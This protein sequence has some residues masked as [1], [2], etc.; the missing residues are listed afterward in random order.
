MTIIQKIFSSASEAMTFLER[1]ASDDKKFV[2]RGHSK[3][4]YQ[5]QTTWRR[6]RSVPYAAWMTDID[7]MLEAFRTGLAKMG[8]TPFPGDG[9]QDWLEFGRHHGVPT[10]ALDFSYSPYVALFFAFDGRRINYKEP[11][12]D[13][14]VVYALDVDALATAWASRVGGPDKGSEDW[15]AARDA[16]LR[17]DDDFFKD[18]FPVGELKF[19]PQPGIHNHRMHRQLGCLLY[20]TVNLESAALNTLDPLI[21]SFSE[22]ATHG[23]PSSPMPT[24]FRILID[25]SCI[26]EVL[27]KLELMNINGASLY[28]S[29]DGVARDVVNAYNYNPKAMW[30]R[31][32]KFKPIVE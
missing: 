13:Y 9:R 29:A 11:I 32:I 4:D 22:P 27:S 5:L 12:S 21:E 19:L 25:V 15:Y 10:P 26:S 3:V 8:L 31:E 18:G 17:Q 6:H 30:L 1:L 14:V 28:L 16:F 2:F 20:D 24:A 23:D 7:E